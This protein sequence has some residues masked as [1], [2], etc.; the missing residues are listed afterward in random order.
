MAN[1]N[2]Q[3]HYI[4][5]KDIS[6][7]PSFYTTALKDQVENRRF[8]TMLKPS[9]S[10]CNIDCTYCFYLH[11][12]SLL[13]QPKKP[14]M[15]YQILEQH[16]RQ[17]IEAQSG[18]EVVFSWQGGE[19]TLMGLDFFKQV[20][21][22]QNKYA[23]PYQK[24]ANDLQTN[25]ILLTD[26]WCYFLKQ[27]EFLVGISIDG[28]ASL[29]DIYRQ[30]KTGK[31]TFN[32]VMAAIKKLQHFEIPFSALCVINNE[33]VKKPLTVYRFLKNEVKPRLIQF[34]PGMEKTD[35]K[36]SA[37]GYWTN[38]T[39]SG[40]S[41]EKKSISPVTDWSVAPD[42]WGRFLN[43]VWDEWVQHD[44]GEVFVDQFENVLSMLLGKGAQQCVTSE[45]CGKALALEHNGD[46]YSCD[47]FVY[48]EYKLGN[49]LQQH[50]GHLAFSA[51]QEK[52]AHA[53]S[54]RL[55][56]A[57]KRCD[58]LKLCWGHCPKDRFMKTADGESG[59]H[60]LC[61]GLKLFYQHVIT[62]CDNLM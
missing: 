57:C 52:F 5:I 30:G 15:S 26:E 54:N 31:P 3:K 16:I 48:P 27:H 42:D 10:Q 44:F 2:Q 50:E 43:A 29:H 22:L 35:F 1:V 36:E 45:I 51:K 37:P 19:P 28:P 59:L 25:G 23:K 56:K 32:K 53:K 24:I 55:P 58:Y 12:S 8:H 34:I 13:A 40:C 39:S 4:P 60:Y 46:L 38:A 7:Q 33:N 17:Y 14:R 41:T 21:A 49:I 61:S 9:G 11:K 62:S 6:L 18:N 47:H 20:V